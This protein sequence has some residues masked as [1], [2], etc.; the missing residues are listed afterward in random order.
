MK[1]E[2][3]LNLDAFGEPCIN[4]KHYHKSES[5]EQKLLGKFIDSFIKNESSGL[6][7]VSQHS[8]SG[9][10]NDSDFFKSYRIVT[11]SKKP[12]NDPFK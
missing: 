12:I 3:E 2:L 1:V 7:L 9:S 10:V 11:G 4:I 6:I 5:L 8:K